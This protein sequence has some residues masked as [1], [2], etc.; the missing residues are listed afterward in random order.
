M[1]SQ[2][3]SLAPRRAV[4]SGELARCSTK[5]TAPRRLL[6]ADD[7]PQ[8]RDS[9]GKVLRQA[10]YDVSPACNGSQVV[11]LLFERSF[12]LVLLDLNMPG[13][14]GWETLGHIVS[15][16]PGL[17]VVVITAQGEQREWAIS[18]GARFLMEKPLDL[19]LLLERIRECIENPAEER[20]ARS[21]PFRFDGGT[22]RE[23]RF[24]DPYQGR[25]ST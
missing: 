13:I 21:E 6:L 22:R 11:D 7:S 2:T 5:P 12:D 14:D 20:P 15:L 9:L 24:A 17:P 16:R 4:I 3:S 18:E 1:N 8:I 19:P 23:F 25:S 10:G